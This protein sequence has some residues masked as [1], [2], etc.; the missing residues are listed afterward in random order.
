MIYR[1]ASLAL[2]LLLVVAASLA[3]SAIEA[4]EWYY[5]TMRRPSIAPPGWLF[6]MVSALV[7]VCMAVAAWKI[8]LTE[9]YSR[10]GV[11]TWWALLLV[12]NVS[13]SVVFFGLNR[14]G[15]ALPVVV[16]AIGAAIFCIRAFSPLSRPAGYLVAPFLGWIAFVGV[17]NLAVW[18]LNGG[19]L[20][21]FMS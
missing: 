9:H 12:L 10:L 18:T 14:P 6:A 2:F 19:L 5:I 16:A 11:L 20:A 3:G 1:Y 15:W 8:W 7:Y 21:R 17:F 13:W 4:G